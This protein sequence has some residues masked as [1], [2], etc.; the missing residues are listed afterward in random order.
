M[1][2]LVLT[3]ILLSF[4]WPAVAR[5]YQ[6]QAVQAPQAAVA[7]QE[8]TIGSANEELLKGTEF[9]HKR[10]TNLPA[11]QSNVFPTW[12]WYWNEKAQIDTSNKY[13][14]WGNDSVGK[15]FAELTNSFIAPVWNISMN[16]DVV[17]ILFPVAILL[18]IGLTFMQSRAGQNPIR[19]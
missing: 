3:V 9:E 13:G 18:S 11:G 6:N 16:Y 14:F 8:P 12:Q 7:S 17:R 19:K 2:K 15:Q 1:K 5:N 4:L 10:D